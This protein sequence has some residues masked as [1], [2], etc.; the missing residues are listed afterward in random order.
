MVLR[1]GSILAVAGAAVGLG[2]AVALVRAMESL[3]YGVSPLDPVTFA[4]AALLLFVVASAASYFPARRA[5]HVDPVYAL[6]SE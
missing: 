4:V 1:R 3:L 2:G 5:A 6:R